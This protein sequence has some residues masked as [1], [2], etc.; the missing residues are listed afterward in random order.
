MSG[1]LHPDIKSVLI[2]EGKIQAK[3]KQL[4]ARICKDYKGKKPIFIGILKG[5]VPFLADLL[6]NISVDCM[7]DFMCLSSYSGD[8]S[9]GVVRTLLDLRQNIE[10]RHIIIVEDIVDTGLTMKYLL[11]NLNSRKPKSVE[12]CA[13]LDKPSAR[14]SPVKIKYLGFSIPEKFV[15]GYGLDYC[16]MHR[17]LPYVGVLKD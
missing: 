3:V 9:T 2:S 1:K 16:E 4:A 14:K 17:N 7:V 13:L 6:K 10:G 11:K 5:S 15:V 12:V 8:K